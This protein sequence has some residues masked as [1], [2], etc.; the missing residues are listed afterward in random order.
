MTPPS[1]ELLPAPPARWPARTGRDAHA[2]YDVDAVRL[3]SPA[4]ADHGRW[5][6]GQP[7]VLDAALNSESDLAWGEP[8]AQGVRLRPL[9][10]PGPYTPTTLTSA[11]TIEF[12][13]PIHDNQGTPFPDS[14]FALF[15]SHLI[16][17]AGGF[18]HRGF[19]EGAWKAPDGA[20]Y[21]DR[22]RLYVVQ[23]SESDAPTVAATIDAEIR[24]RFRQLA[25]YLAI[26][27]TQALAS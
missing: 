12:L 17:L 24:G 3:G 11:I 21:R 19:V 5:G 16:D 8:S 23:V 22:S 25:A 7:C 10:V 13:V 14:T 4:T 1:P 2:R 9:P 27:R 26:S 18:T 20:I 15:E 6:T